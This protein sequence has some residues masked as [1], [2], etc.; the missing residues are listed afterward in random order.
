VPGWPKPGPART[1]FGWGLAAGAAVL[2]LFAAPTPYVLYEPGIVVPADELVTVEKRERPDRKAPESEARDGWLLATVYLRDRAAPW[3]VISSAWRRD[4]EAHARRSVF[5]GESG[6]E[7]RRRMAVLAEESHAKALMAAFRAAGVRYE[8][9]PDGVYVVRGAGRLR[10]GD[11]IAAVD[12]AAVRG[13][14]ELADALGVRAGRNA[15]LTVM[16]DG[17]AFTVY[18]AADEGAAE[19][20]APD[21]TAAD[22]T[23]GSGT[24]GRFAADG[25]AGSGA[26][27]VATAASAPRRLA[28]AELTER[29]AV[30]P[31]DPGLRVA[32]DTG[33]LAGPSAGLPLALHIYG[34]LTGEPLAGGRRIAA[35]GTIEPSGA[36]GAVGGAGLK[37]IAA[38]RAGADLFLVPEANRAEAAAAAESEGGGM[39]V[40]GVRTLE[41]ALSLLR[42]DR[43]LP[44]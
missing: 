34:Q 14:D 9:V 41:D 26:G 7:Y 2:F 5:R 33:G 19:E 20:S 31:E 24:A 32:I 40:A 17:R 28:G 18:V 37:A 30:R 42:G 6:E 21:G 3:Q 36:V 12:G 35:T 39:S 11:R 29:F 43:A 10:A 1:A 15:E 4:R 13:L 44:R 25:T 38:A 8:A 23:A 16:R 22:G 27:T